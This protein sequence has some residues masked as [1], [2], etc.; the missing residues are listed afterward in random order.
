MADPY[1]A[2]VMKHRGLM[3]S[4]S[5]NG[6]TDFH[7]AAAV[8]TPGGLKSTYV[9]M[10]ASPLDTWRSGGEIPGALAPAV[11]PKGPENTPVSGPFSVRISGKPT[12]SDPLVTRTTARSGTAGSPFKP[13]S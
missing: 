2:V 12:G 11:K 5:S 9:T 3:I 1:A 6:T 8:R 4:P 10:T 13:S 7:V